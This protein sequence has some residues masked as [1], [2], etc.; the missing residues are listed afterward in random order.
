MF[1]KN[2]GT[3]GRLW[4]FALAMALLAYAYW[5]RSWIAFAVGLFV[6][7]ESLM[8][9]CF[10]NQILGRSSCPIDRDSDQKK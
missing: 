9:W 4:R 7:F 6:L 8:S 10:L 2:I 5:Q 1:K 3:S